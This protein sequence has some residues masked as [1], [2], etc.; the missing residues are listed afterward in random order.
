MS[1]DQFF[2][3][4]ILVWA[5][6]K[7]LVISLVYLGGSVKTFP[8]SSLKQPT[9]YWYDI[10]EW[11]SYKSCIYSSVTSSIVRLFTCQWGGS[12]GDTSNCRRYQIKVRVFPER[13]ILDSTI[14]KRK[15]SWS[16]SRDDLKSKVRISL[17]ELTFRYK[18]K[19]IVTTCVK[20]FSHFQLHMRKV[21]L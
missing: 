13:K 6:K 12:H 7:S 9:R 2:L 15:H 19:D 20:S 10:I 16:S 11:C 21:K 17:K 5:C 3:V 18:E 1:R 8:V 14:F 4:N